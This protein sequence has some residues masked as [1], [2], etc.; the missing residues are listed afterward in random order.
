MKLISIKENIGIPKYKQIINAI[1]NAISI[2]NLKKGDE[3]PSVNSICKKFEISRDTVFSAYNELKSRG[4]IQ[5]FPGKGYYIKSENLEI[6]QKIF[7]LFDELNAFKEDLYNAFLKNISPNIQLNIYFHHFDFEVFSKLIYDNI[8]NYNRYIIMPANLKNTNSVIEKLPKERVYIL[9]Q[10]HNDLKVYSGIYQN[11]EKDIFQNLILAKS[12][13]K[14]YQKLILL[15]QNKQPKGILNGFK[16]FCLANNFKYE[17]IET[18]EDRAL[19]IGEVYIIPDDRNLIRIVKKIKDV[20]LKLGHE[21]GIISYNETLLKEI[22]EG[23]IT[24]I[25]TDFKKMGAELAALI[26]QNEILQIEN[27]SSLIIRNSL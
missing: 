11:F 1:E 5:S 26:Q 7:L 16:K 14:K 6:K 13:L 8:G 17:N 3:I 10:M 15:F 21:I 23:G 9:D 25:S 18:L 27:S 4:I 20:S 2:G 12:Y 24:T 19:N 22:I